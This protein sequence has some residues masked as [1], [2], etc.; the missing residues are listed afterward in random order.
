MTIERYL[1]P[2]TQLLVALGAATAAKCQNCFTKLYGMTDAVG[3]T[4]EEVRAVVAIADKVAQKSHAFMS[5][6]IAETTKGAVTAHGSDTA[7]SGC[8]A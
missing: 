4:P 8:S 6:F 2:K 7:G 5:V 3:V 1:E